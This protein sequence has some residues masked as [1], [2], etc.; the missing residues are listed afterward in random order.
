MG[1]SAGSVGRGRGHL[2]QPTKVVLGGGRTS[3]EGWTHS[4][5]GEGGVDR[6]NGKARQEERYL[7]E[8][9]VDSQTQ[10]ECGKVQERWMVVKKM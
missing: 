5:D 6:L 8:P 10:A 7:Q 2:P 4:W 3:G 1:L 9:R